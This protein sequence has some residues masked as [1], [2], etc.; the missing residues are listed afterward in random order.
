MSYY[1]IIIKVD[2]KRIGIVGPFDA[3]CVAD[4]YVDRF[5]AKWMPNATFTVEKLISPERMY[6]AIGNPPPDE[7]Y[8]PSTRILPESPKPSAEEW[9]STHYPQKT[10][11]K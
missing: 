5:L 8:D 6:M 10:L 11:D 3:E 7:E 1:I 2:N 9:I 4:M